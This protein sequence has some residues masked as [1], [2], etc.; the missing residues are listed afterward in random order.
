MCVSNCTV[1]ITEVLNLDHRPRNILQCFAETEA[2]KAITHQVQL[3]TYCHVLLQSYPVPFSS[4]HFCD[5]V[6]D[7]CRMVYSISCFFFAGELNAN[8]LR[9]TEKEIW[10]IVQ[11]VRYLL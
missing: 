6:Q 9:H 4:L 1:A 11:W 5:F 2:S 10:G 8:F 7:N 3:S